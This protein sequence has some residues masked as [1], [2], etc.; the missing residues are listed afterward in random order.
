MRVMV[1]EQQR[2]VARALGQDIETDSAAAVALSHAQYL[3]RVGDGSE[4]EYVKDGVE[5]ISRTFLI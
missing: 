5:Y 2:R 4:A 1:L 3:E